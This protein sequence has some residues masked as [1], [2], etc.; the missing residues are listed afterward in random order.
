MSKGFDRVRTRV[1]TAESAVATTHDS[2]GKRAL[3][4]STTPESDLPGPAGSV[5]VD[6]GRCGA[7]T[8]LSPVAAMRAA[9]PSL[10]LSIGVGRGDRESTVG[11]VR[12]HNGAFLR[13]PA[14]GRGSWTRL[15]VRI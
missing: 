3:F 8:A 12:R 15:T 2:E 9:L 4:S 7:R 5:T 10:L 6:C 1:P 11:L 13:C 14:C